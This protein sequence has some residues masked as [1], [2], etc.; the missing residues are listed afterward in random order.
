MSFVRRGPG[1]ASKVSGVGERRRRG[2]EV[3]RLLQASGKSVFIY[4]AVCSECL[5]IGTFIGDRLFPSPSSR[6]IF[7]I[8]LLFHRALD[9]IPRN[10][11]LVD[12]SF[13]FSRGKL[14]IRVD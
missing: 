3:E 13:F 11:F 10:L 8:V 2:G 9:R 7:S 1:N 5:F 6:F 14:G 12:S 4:G